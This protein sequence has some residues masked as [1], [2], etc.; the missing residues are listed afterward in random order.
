MRT[1]IILAS[2]AIFISFLLVVMGILFGRLN[3]L[4]ESHLAYQ[5]VLA[6]TTTPAATHETFIPLGTGSVD[7][8]QWTN[9]PG[10]QAQINTGLYKKMQ[11]VTFEVGIINPNDSGTIF[12]RLYNVTGNYPVWSST[13][14]LDSNS[15]YIVSGPVILPAGSNLYQ[16]QMLNTL[17]APAQLAMSRLRIISY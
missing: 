11:T 10:L 1:K 17:N 9:V 4:S 15:G 8:N 3:S 16:V 5:G 7:S 13:V 2:S 6:A 12:V 14:S